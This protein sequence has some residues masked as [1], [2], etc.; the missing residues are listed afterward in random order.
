[1][2]KLTVPSVSKK[3]EKNLK[4]QDTIYISCI[5]ND[6]NF[7]IHRVHAATTENYK[8]QI[9]RLEADLSRIQTRKVSQLVG[10]F[11]N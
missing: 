6:G 5:H 3:R 7:I 10:T 1:M 2:G 9:E 4:F 8:V 11:P